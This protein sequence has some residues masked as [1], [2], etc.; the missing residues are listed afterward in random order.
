MTERLRIVAGSFEVR[1]GEV[2]ELVRRIFP[3]VKIERDNH[4]TIDEE[5]YGW[6]RQ[7]SKTSS[8]RYAKGAVRVPQTSRIKL[9]KTKIEDPASRSHVGYLRIT[10]VVVKK[11][12]EL[13][14]KD[15]KNDGLGGKDQLIEVLQDFYDTEIGD[16]EP[17]SIFEF[18]FEPRR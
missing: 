10:R 9:I 14:D 2:E 1:L 7:G 4:L 3:G 17:V 8:V 6:V 11:F 13:S 18:K 15:A 12:G 5:Y 16:S